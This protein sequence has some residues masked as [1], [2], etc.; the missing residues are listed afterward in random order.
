MFQ[1][2]KEW[3][4][5]KV[6]QDKVQEL[7]AATQIYLNQT[8]AHILCCLMKYDSSSITAFQATNQIYFSRVPSV[9]H[10]H[11]KCMP[12]PTTKKLDARSQE[13]ANYDKDHARQEKD[14]I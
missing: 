10:A 2:L 8:S 12:Y 11:A 7:I 1:T 14:Q 5:V 3:H 4:S 6:T 9:S 13:R